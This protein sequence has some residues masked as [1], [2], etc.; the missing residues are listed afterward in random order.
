[1][2]PRYGPNSVAVERLLGDLDRLPTGEIAALAAAGGGDVGTAEDDPD[3]VARAG[4]R[5]R[6][7]EIAVQG[8]RL[9]AV[10]AV[11]DEVASWASSTSHWFPAGIAGT[12]D[13]TKDMGPRLA[14]MPIVLD[15]A[16]AA[17]LEDLLAAWELHLLMAPWADVIGSPFGD[18]D[19]PGDGR[20]A[21]D[22]EGADGEPSD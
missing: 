2:A 8:N 6:L 13:S 19:L 10:R 11:G 5:A 1:M 15:A 7:R 20:P 16:Y 14:A 22:G 21:P 4:V 17:V 12:A 3:V 18:R 9:D